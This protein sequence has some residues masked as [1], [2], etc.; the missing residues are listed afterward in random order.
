[1]RDLKGT[2]VSS[3]PKPVRERLLLAVHSLKYA[4]GHR[5]ILNEVKSTGKVR[6]AFLASSLAM[7]KSQELVNLLLND[8]RF[9]V[10]VV[11]TPI[12]SYDIE[13]QKADMQM[14]RSFFDG[15]N[16]Q[17]V[18]YSF[19]GKPYDL[20]KEFNPHI[21]F[22]VQTYGNI[23]CKEHDSES[24]PECLNAYIPYSFWPGNEPWGFDLMFHRKAWRIYYA[25]DMLLD[26]AK[27][28][29]MINA[30]NGRIVGYPSADLFCVDNHKDVWK[31]KNRS[32]KRI[33]WA[34]HFTITPDTGI[35]NS[36]SSFFNL[37]EGMVEYA[38]A[39]QDRLQIA[40]K[41]HP[42]LKTEL[43]KQWGK[44]RT[45]AYYYQWESMPNTQ[46]ETGA[47]IDLFMT[48]DALVHECGSFMIEY[49]YSQNPCMYVMEGFDHFYDGMNAL[50]QKALDL[51]YKGCNMSDVEAFINEVVFDGKDTQREAR[52][53]FFD[54]QLLPPNNK[55]TARNICDDLVKSLFKD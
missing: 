32:I 12:I 33:I 18:D 24:F 40:F 2:I 1:M 37:Y 11:L 41:P 5:H 20:K 3:L 17:Y 25:N 38:I 49:H 42:R 50:G 35:G 4:A 14:L 47:Y 34:P 21:I 9:D 29:S 53:D 27:S 45:D 46:L 51:H 22:F 26:V 8:K 6:I 43:Y 39:N 13:V 48:S 30:R 15:N 55:S 23:H 31:I 10:K 44:E 36:H 52:K 28:H 7:W 54:S 19:D 16:T